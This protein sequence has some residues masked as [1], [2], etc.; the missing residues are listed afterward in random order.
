[1]YNY[2]DTRTYFQGNI[3]ADRGPEPESENKEQPQPQE[4][5]N[6]QTDDNEDGEDQD[7]QEGQEG[8]EVEEGNSTAPVN[9]KPVD[10]NSNGDLVPVEKPFLIVYNSQL[11]KSLNFD[12]IEVNK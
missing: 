8:Q 10:N 7:V 3:K 4:T 12:V 9:E 5:E 1:M 6:R 11:T 2:I